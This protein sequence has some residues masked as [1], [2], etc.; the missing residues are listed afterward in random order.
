[1]K[2]SLGFIGDLFLLEPLHLQSMSL[3]ICRLGSI[4]NK[5]GGGIYV[6]TYQVK[7]SYNIQIL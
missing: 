7:D 1:M 5:N 2:Q 6:T 4:V 3:H